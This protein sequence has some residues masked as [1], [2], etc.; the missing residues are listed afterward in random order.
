MGNDER[1]SKKNLPALTRIYPAWRQNFK[2]KRSDVPT[3]KDRGRR[4]GTQ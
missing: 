1:G 4:L 2:R 3:L